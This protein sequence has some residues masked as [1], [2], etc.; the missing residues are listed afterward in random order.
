M[1]QTKRWI[2]VGKQSD[3]I[4]GSGV[5]A[6]VGSQQVALFWIP[7]LENR[8]FAVS[9]YCPFCGVNIIARGILGDIGGEPVVASPLYKQHF[10]LLDGRCLEKPEVALQTWDVRLQ[11]D[12]VQVRLR[13][14]EEMAA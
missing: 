4:P 6:K 1:S 7:E 13:A 14:E 8:V 9:N 5:G 10:S 11:G 2:T 3:L 12:E